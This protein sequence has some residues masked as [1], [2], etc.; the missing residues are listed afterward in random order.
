M[1]LVN[2]ILDKLAVVELLQHS[3]NSVS[4]RAEMKKIIIGGKGRDAIF[5]NHKQLQG[6]VGGAGASQRAAKSMVEYLKNRK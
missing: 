6:K 3:F 1:S 5:D 4:L 2:L